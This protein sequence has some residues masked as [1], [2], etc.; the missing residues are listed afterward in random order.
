M[1][2]K[3]TARTFLP[4]ILTPGMGGG[5][6]PAT[7]RS[8]IPAYNVPTIQ[9]VLDGK[10][11][12]IPGAGGA[13]GDWDKGGGFGEENDALHS[14][15]EEANDYKRKER[16]LGI[17]MQ[18]E[19]YSPVKDSLE[20]WKVKIPG[21][22]KTFTSFEAMLAYKQEMAM[23]GLNVKWIARTKVAQK[24][25][26]DVVAESM[27]STF[28]I[29]SIDIFNGVVEKGECFCVANG[30]FLTCAHVIKKYNKNVEKTLDINDIQS[31][32]RV[33]IVRGNQKFPA[34]VMDINLPLD[35]ALV[36]AD[37]KCKPLLLEKNLQ[38]GEELFTIGSPHG[39]ENNVSFGK[40]GSLNRKIYQ[41]EGA[42]E[43][44]F[45][46]LAVFSGNSGGPAIKSS[47]GK[48]VAMITAI[49]SSTGEYGLNAGL[50]STYLESFCVKNRIN[51]V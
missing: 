1:E 22:S 4:E 34:K 19:Q 10:P 48:V 3:K 49:V 42:P 38:I 50:P 32:L 44:V 24:T 29:E 26:T 33:S 17:L 2:I 45:L 39:F 35:V 21:G 51:I 37:I 14:Y 25:E 40:V 31:K 46:D 12:K 47:D 15:K 8:V 28:M 27:E 16:D 18:M 20:E 6:S 11:Y 23:S 9:D 5:L 13:W 43:Y 30:I 36:Q 41:H 7:D